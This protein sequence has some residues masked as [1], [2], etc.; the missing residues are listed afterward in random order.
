MTRRPELLILI[1]PVSIIIILIVVG[2][3]LLNSGSSEADERTIGLTAE[4]TL[5]SPDGVLT[6]A[7]TFRQTA[8]GVL[9]MADVK[10]LVSGGHAFII[11]EVGACSTRLQRRR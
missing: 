8:S 10:G 4:A 11:H 1:G 6:G 5:N 9:I 2:F 3:I 7:V